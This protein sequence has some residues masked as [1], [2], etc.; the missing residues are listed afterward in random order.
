[1]PP[2][3]AILFVIVFTAAIV[4]ALF[5]HPIYG[6]GAYLLGFYGFPPGRWWWVGMPDIRWLMIAAL[7]TFIA[8]LR[9]ERKPGQPPWYSNTA[10]VLLFLFTVWLWIQQAWA[11]DPTTHNYFATTYTKFLIFF[12]LMYRIL[13]DEESV[14][15]FSL[16]HVLGCA[17]YAWLAYNVTGG[18]RIQDIGGPNMEGT[19]AFSAH[20]TTGLILGGILLFQTRGAVRVG[21][22]VCLAFILNG[23][24]LTQSRGAFLGL[25]A[26][27]LVVL[28]LCPPK[29]KLKMYAAAVL[30]S[31]L[32]LMLASEAFW[33]RMESIFHAVEQTE[34]MDGSAEG[35]WLLIDA[36]WK[37]FALNPVTG[38]GHRG[39]A[40]L[41]PRYL[42]E[43][44]LVRSG[45]RSSHNTFMSL[46]VEQGIVGSALYGML[47]LWA[48]Y[49]LVRMKALD[50]YGLPPS[51]G[52]YRAAIG[53]ALANMAVAGMFFDALRLEVTIWFVILL[54]IVSQL[55]NEAIAKVEQGAPVA[56]PEE[57][58]PRTVAANGRTLG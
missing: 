20:A 14:K 17:Y 45:G 27:G 4:L 11:L 37:M 21:L 58:G 42:S 46:I 22:L 55:A 1:M 43:E 18:G 3:S 23:I 33:Q 6:L 28:Y 56:A 2:I 36:Q 38:S 9:F 48:M 30:A 39:T 12:F 51:L 32:F 24:I 34:E 35:R 25:I 52:L 15:L 19:S 16:A 29:K 26:G 47:M 49:R 10:M 54:V 31:V 5:R 8:V 7:V 57:T 50:R 53:G 13:Q 41:S 44:W 40:V